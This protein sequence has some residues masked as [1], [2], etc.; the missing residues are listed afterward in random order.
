M[1]PSCRGSTTED[2]LNRIARQH[3]PDLAEATRLDEKNILEQGLQFA[4]DWLQN[5]QLFG[6]KGFQWVAI[7]VTIGA[8]SICTFCFCCRKNIEKAATVPIQAV[9]QRLQR[10]R[11]NGGF[12]AAFNRNRPET[13]EHRMKRQASSAHVGVYVPQDSGAGVHTVHKSGTYGTGTYSDQGH[14]VKERHAGSSA[15]GV[16]LPPRGPNVDPYDPGN[17]SVEVSLG[18][19]QAGGYMGAAQEHTGDVKVPGQ[20]K[21]SPRLPMLSP[22]TNNDVQRPAGNY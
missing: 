1:L 21:R 15:G 12:T 3:N 5:E 4:T 22:R 14:P 7:L 13:A 9:S 6:I 18:D 19:E 10:A 2:E 20:E 17:Y 11:E 16:M 8:I